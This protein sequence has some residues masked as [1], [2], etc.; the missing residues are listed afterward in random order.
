[1][2]DFGAVDDDRYG[3]FV[4]LDELSFPGA[5]PKRVQLVLDDWYDSLE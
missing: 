2:R 3:V 1:V 4:M 5:D